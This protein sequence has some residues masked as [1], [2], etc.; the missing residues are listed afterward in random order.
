MGFNKFDLLSNAPKNF[1]FQHHSNK[2]NFGGVLTLVLLIISLIIFSYYLISFI[3]EEDYSIQYIKYEYIT[4]T[5]ERDKKKND[6]RY[7]PNIIF[8]FELRYTNWTSLPDDF[9]LVNLSNN[10]LIPRR[11]ILNAKVTDFFLIGILYKC[12]DEKSVN[13]TDECESPIDIITLDERYQGFDVDH[14]N[15][16]SP[17]HFM[18]GHHN[19]NSF[20]F[21]PE[22]ILLL[23]ETWENVKYNPESGFTKLWKSL[24]GIDIEQQKYIGIRRD[25]F[26]LR[27]L[28]VSYPYEDINGTKYRTISRFK[29][30]VDF[31]HWDEYSRTKKSF[32]DLISSVFSLSLGV[33][34]FLTSFLTGFYSNNFDNYKIVEK[35][36]YDVKKVK[37]EKPTKIELTISSFKEDSL[38]EENEGDKDLNDEE[39]IINE[40]FGNEN[41]DVHDIYE[42][43]KENRK[44]RILPKFRFIDFLFNNFYSNKTCKN[45]RQQII[46]KYNDLIT[47]YYS[48]E[49]IVFNQIK[50]E[51]LLKDYKWNNPD[52]ADIN[53]NELIIQL[54]NLI[55][56]YKVDY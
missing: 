1:I 10:Q 20:M 27:H 21:Q 13:D 38:L 26:D 56:S 28:F 35:L 49:T 14:Q 8:G 43:E 11:G 24:Q 25:R 4:S 54:N 33:F 9:V 7:N 51:N 2:T 47:K 39:N 34:N 29:Y 41:E 30:D 31:Y 22:D 42:S 52:L 40:N 48:I 37:K 6:T 32:L 18:E 53:N 45:I 23:T 16:T 5:E 50:M 15:S 17:I 55:S 12:P 3:T 44:K 36:L 46:A 19:F